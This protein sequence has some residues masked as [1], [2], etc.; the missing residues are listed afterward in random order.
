MTVTPGKPPVTD[1]QWVREMTQRVKALEQPGN[2][3]IGSWTLHEQDGNLHATK[4]GQTVQ[5]T[6]PDD[7]ATPT[8]VPVARNRARISFSDFG[9][10]G[11]GATN[12]FSLIY[13]NMQTPNIVVGASGPSATDI[14]NALLGLF[15]EQ[16]TLLD[17]D[18]IQLSGSTTDWIITYPGG[19]LQPGPCTSTG[20]TLPVFTLTAYP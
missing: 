11:F 16:Y 17:F 10:V 6:F 13:R 15:P 7:A 14:T 3:T 4:A 5:L 12:T 20:A 2:V 18:V 19:N 9:T 1:P 8:N